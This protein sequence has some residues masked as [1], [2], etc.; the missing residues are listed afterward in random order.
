MRL[1]PILGFAFASLLPADSAPEF[2]RHVTLRGTT[3]HV[4]LATQVGRPYDTAAV[5]ADVHRLWNTG[6]FADIRVDKTEEAEGVGLTF[7]VVESQIRPLHKILIEPSTFG[8]QVNLPE[9]TPLD[10]PRA[11]E[12]AS[13]ARQE[14][15]ARGFQDPAVDY[16]LV[17]YIGKQVDLRLHV[18]QGGRVRAKTVD[19][20]GDLAIDPKELHGALQALRVR[21]ILPGLPGIWSG[22]R[23]YP[24]YTREAVQSDMA[25]LRSLYI[26]KGYMDAAVRWDNVD[27]HDHQAGLTVRIQAGPRYRIRSAAIGDDSVQV[28]T[29]GDLCSG[30]LARRRAAER[31]GILDFRARLDTRLVADDDVRPIAHLATAIERGR[32]YRIGRIEFSGHRHFSESLLR[33]NLLLDEGQLLDERL[34]RKS[35]ARLNQSMLFEPI[36]EPDVHIRTAQDT[37]IADV[38][39]Q[40]RERKSGAWNFSGPVGPASFAGPLE[41]S[42]RSRLPSWGSGLFELSTYTAAISM[43]AFAPPLVPALSIVD[44][45][46]LLPVLAL[47]RPFIPGEGWKAG[48]YVAPQ[49][50]WKALALG[51]SVTQSQQRLLPR[52]AGDRALTPDLPV[53]VETPR[54]EA[55]MFCDPPQPRLMPL[56]TGVSWALRFLGAFTGL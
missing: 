31:Q 22:W 43:Y 2:V 4:D 55:T 42:L 16:Q 34:L 9:G 38:T 19:F 24:A 18:D 6:R 56:R 39:I 44:Q 52:L 1:T 15:R 12:I 11:R 40:L 47:Q 33:H 30:L 51:Y 29:P 21:R 5:S 37:G 50:G 54:G 41:A 53:T 26:T 13:Q 8:L 36:A 10:R 27:L 32:P 17:P 28:E 46:P 25:R 23:L 3:L 7:Q 49:L 14:L 35:M 45:H 48:F 20:V